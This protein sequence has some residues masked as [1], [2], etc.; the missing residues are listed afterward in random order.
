[1]KNAD[2]LRKK[3]ADLIER[4]GD[5]SI[6]QIAQVVVN[7][8][9]KLPDVQVVEM[10]EYNRLEDDNRR[11]RWKCSLMRIQMHGDCGV[12]KHRGKAICRDCL[13]SDRR[14]SWEYEGFP[15]FFEKCGGAE[16]GK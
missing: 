4:S 11:L 2:I 6:S 9:D 14:D 7:E 16:D 3:F 12:C 15:V 10:D 8:I 13:N 1:M 5:N